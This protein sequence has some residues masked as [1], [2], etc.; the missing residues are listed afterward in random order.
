MARHQY[1]RDCN[2]AP[3]GVTFLWYDELFQP[4]LVPSGSLM[5]SPSLSTTFTYAPAPDRRT[6]TVNGAI[7]GMYSGP[8]VVVHLYVEQGPQSYTATQQ[9][10]AQGN[11]VPGTEM[12]TPESDVSYIREIQT[13]L[14]LSPEVAI[15][16][17]QYLM[18]QGERAQVQWGKRTGT[19]A[20]GTS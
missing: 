8:N 6:V 5:S 4:W 13:T 7:G 10:D 19:S 14:V 9:W 12:A 3:W 16:L 20:P 15:G 17:G 11:M 18:T 2:G 1:Q